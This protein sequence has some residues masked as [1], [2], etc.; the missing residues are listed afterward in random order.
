MASLRY[1]LCLLLSI[2]TH[3]AHG[4]KPEKFTDVDFK[5]WQQKMLFYLTTLNLAR[6]LNE[7]APKLDEGDIDKER[8]AAVDAW[9]HSDFLC[10]NY[11][12]NGLDNALYNVYSPP[13]N[14]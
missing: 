9:K 12:L 2:P 10:R 11:I 6:F 14:G 7:D 4:E 3:G 5:R 1:P 8:L 13:E